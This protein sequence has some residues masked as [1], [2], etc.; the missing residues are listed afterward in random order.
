M[1]GPIDALPAAAALRCHG[2][3]DVALL[4][5]PRGS[6]SHRPGRSSFLPIDGRHQRGSGALEALRRLAQLQGHGIDQRRV[7]SGEQRSPAVE[8]RAVA[9]RSLCHGVLV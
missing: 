7:R 2:A 8:A 3:F 6:Q 5:A 4:G 1:R 9:K